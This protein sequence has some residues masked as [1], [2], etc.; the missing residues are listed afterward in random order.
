MNCR[1]MLVVLSLATLTATGHAGLVGDTV[2]ATELSVYTAQELSAGTALVSAGG[3]EF[4]YLLGSS[5]FIDID[6]Q[7]TYIDFTFGAASPTSNALFGNVLNQVTIGD[8]DP[9]VSAVALTEFDVTNAANPVPALSG[10]VASFT[11]NSVTL[12]IKNT[13]S[14]GDRVRLDLTFDNGGNVPEPGT[15]ALAGLMLVG[16]T[17]SRRRRSQPGEVDRFGLNPARVHTAS[18]R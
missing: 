5:R 10:N 2:T 7:D 12:Q 11:A 9:I 8:I 3:P 13:W 15:L 4:R 14:V 6:V 16:L 1:S 17:W 18:P